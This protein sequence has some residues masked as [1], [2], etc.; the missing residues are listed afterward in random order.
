VSGYDNGAP[1]KPYYSDDAVTIFHGD[2]LEL[3]GLGDKPSV[4]S[5]GLAAVVPGDVLVTDP[6]Y[7]VNYYSGAR[8]SMGTPAAIRGDEDTTLRD[9]L[10]SIWGGP[11]LVFGSWKAPRPHATHTR[12]I[13]DTK[14]ALGMG[15]LR[16]PWKPSD[17]EIYVLGQGFS[18]PRTSNVLSVAPVQ[19][20]ASNGRVHPHEKPVPLLRMLIEKCPPGTILDPFMGSGTTLRA[21]KDLGRKAIGIEIEEKYCQIAAERCAQEVLDFGAAA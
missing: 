14:G 9:D 17:Q 12:L 21:A 5:E 6:P 16:V 18:G 20:M 4:W 7:G 3:I 8:R 1:V 2:A 15:D 11:A 10:L 13:W 19:S